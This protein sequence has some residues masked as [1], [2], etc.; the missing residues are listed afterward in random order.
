VASQLSKILSRKTDTVARYGGE[1]FIVLLPNT[2]TEDGTVIADK[3]VRAVTSIALQHE[4]INVQIS[5]SIGLHTVTPSHDK[6]SAQL[7]KEADI[8]LYTAK[9]QER[10]CYC[11]A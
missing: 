9:T 10:N 11:I 7:I 3:T 1:E 4:G 6:D 8:A 5:C 2:N